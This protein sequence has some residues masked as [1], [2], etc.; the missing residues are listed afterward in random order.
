MSRRTSASPELI[1]T[2]SRSPVDAALADLEARP[3]GP[4]GIVLVRGRHAEYAHDR[5]ADELLHDA[6]VPTDRGTCH[7]RVLVEHPADVLR[8]GPLRCRG[9]PDEVAEQDADDL[10]LLDAR[11]GDGAVASG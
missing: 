7:R 9:E 6:A 5:I 11:R 2:R 1:P 10:P 4:K 8:V 3:D